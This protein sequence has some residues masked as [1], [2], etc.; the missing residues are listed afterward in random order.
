MSD[1]VMYHSRDSTSGRNLQNKTADV[2][3]PEARFLPLS[4]HKGSY[5]RANHSSQSIQRDGNRHPCLH[6]LVHAPF[7]ELLT[8]LQY[9]QRV[10]QSH[11]L[12]N[13]LLVP[14]VML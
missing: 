4:F 7:C 10:Q 9:R 6:N 12:V 3:A 11:F 8:S 1:L 2:L 5:M 14:P 13:I